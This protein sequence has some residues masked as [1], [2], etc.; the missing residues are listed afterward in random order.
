[1][2]IVPE[3]PTT[4]PIVLGLTAN[5]LRL[6]DVPEVLEVQVIASGE[7]SRVPEAPTATNTPLELELEVVE[8]EL[9]ELLLD[10]SLFF[11]QEKTVRLKSDIRMK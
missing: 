3:K 6:F 11:A 10:E 2:R 8:D 7:V 4:T 9:S 5:D 1:V